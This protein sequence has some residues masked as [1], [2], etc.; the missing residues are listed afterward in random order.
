MSRAERPR[1]LVFQIHP[2]L[3]LLNS[4]EQNLCP[5]GVGSFCGWTDGGKLAAT[6]N[7]SGHPWQSDD[8]EQFS[9]NESHEAGHARNGATLGARKSS[10]VERNSQAVF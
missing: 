9:K 5:T 4:N 10:G 3:S 1:A 6:P 8:L 2:K 7:S